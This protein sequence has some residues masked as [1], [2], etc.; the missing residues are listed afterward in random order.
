M[1][2][3]LGKYLRQLARGRDL[4]DL[5][6]SSMLEAVDR[7]RGS[8]TLESSIGAQLDVQGAFDAAVGGKEMDP[9]QRAAT[10]A[11]I[12]PELRP[13]IDIV[14]GTYAPVTHK[15]W[16]H[17]STD[18]AIKGRIEQAIRSVGRI[19]LPDGP[20]PYAGTGFVVGPSRIMTNRHV[21]AIFAN[22]LGD[23]NI[24]FRPGF[25]AAF[26]LLRERGNNKSIVL[27]VVKVILIHPYWDCAVLEVS[28]LPI[29]APPLTLTATPAEQLRDREVA[30]IGYPAFD[31]RNP[32]SVQNDL[33]DKVFQVKRLQ[34]GVLGEVADAAS[35]GK[36]V[37]AIGHDAS[38]LGGNSGSSLIDLTTGKVVALHFSGV[39]R[40][41]NN[42]V[43]TAE[44]A[45]D[46]RLHDAGVT[47]DAPRPTA[48]PPWAGWWDS[49]SLMERSFGDRAERDSQPAAGSGRPTVQ[50]GGG[51]V[52]VNIP[53]TITVSLGDGAAITAVGDGQAADTTEKLVMPWRDEDFSTRTGYNPL[54]LAGAD[55]APEVPPPTVKD[56]KL[57]ATTS[58]GKD[59]LHYQ[60]FSI[61]MHAKRRLAL[62]SSCNVT[63]EP[64]L[65]RPDKRKAYTRKALSGLGENDQEMWFE[66]PRLADHQQIPDYFYTRD[67]GQFDKGHI[68][69]RDDVAWG[70]TFEELR[71][72]NGDTYHVTNCS[73]QIASFNRSA[74]GVDNWGDLENVVLSQAA[75]ERL[76]VFAGPVLDDKDSWFLGRDKP[77]SRMRAQI[78]TRFW[79]V[80]VARVEE[81]LAT[82]AMMLEQDLSDMPV[83]PEERLEFQVPDSFVK[84]V[85]KLRDIEEWTG[86]VFD[87]AIR[88]ADQYTTVRGPEVALRTGA[89]RR[90]ARRRPS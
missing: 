46:P 85:V 32:A 17:L 87:Q 48:A 8:S 12:L 13:A 44:L 50:L 6:S 49:D 86:L 82:F 71:R 15:L 69:R 30:V 64:A 55:D 42:A 28:G 27:D 77:R 73:P 38:T 54:F 51:K 43:P 22:G 67:D 21:A 9:G 18:A 7:L 23:R 31:S 39:Y 83:A 56:S 26:D 40:E 76:C 53:L 45:A 89:V 74:L 1:A 34:P 79:K 16:T 37:R 29:G 90:R 88:A 72:A 47:F 62:F 59:L 5:L 84:S 52:R 2:D 75:S 58:E 24:V 36:F 65:R 78:P 61:A 3:D 25:T 4:K 81:G 57:L 63:A 35:F 80:V 10:E 19:E 41:R 60:N 11:I 33:F 66:D 20:L 14:N 68:V 70:E